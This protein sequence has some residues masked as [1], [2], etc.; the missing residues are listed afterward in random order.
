[1]NYDFLPPKRTSN[2]HRIS[3]K[4]LRLWLLP[5]L[6]AL[7]VGALLLRPA[8]TPTGA[9]LPPEVAAP[10]AVPP[11]PDIRREVID[12]R[13]ASGDTI[14]A[15]LGAYF[16]PQQ[17]H[18]LGQQSRDIFPLSR[19]SAGQPY[20][21][22]LE[23]DRF[24]EFLYDIDRDDQLL[25]RHS[26][27]G[28]TVERIP[29]EYTTTVES[30]QGVIES[31]LFAAV[32]EIGE[33]DTLAMNL[34]DIFAWDIDFI[35]DIRSGD[36]FQALVEKRFRDGEPAG[37]GRLLAARFV[38]R[39]DSFEAIL[40]QDGDQLP[41]Y[42][43]ADGGS[44]RKAF[45]KAPLAFNR[46]SSGFTM[47]RFH[48]IT[49]TWKAHPAIDYAAPR[50][51]PIKTVGDGVIIKKGYT[52]G[53]GNY[54]KIRHNGGYETMYLHMNGFAKSIRQG[55]RVSQGQVIGYVGSTGLATGPHL[56]FR[57]TKNGAPVNPQRIKLPAANPV[58]HDNLDDFQLLASSLLQ[59][60]D[61][62]PVQVAEQQSDSSS[63]HN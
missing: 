38:N 62:A 43:N 50:G 21:L 49:K 10:P 29:I 17:I 4:R 26:A 20:Q 15:L 55:S 30:V 28:F 27:E 42:Y 11:P 18:Q 5:A 8:V 58:S 2:A 46:I 32:A 39:G 23:D 44:L 51:T 59:Q 25:I 22:H 19:L 53:N 7:I 63:R 48:P 56:C 34:A 12:G 13:V 45:L 33:S 37:Y 57:M 3:R 35:L 1:M 40:F 9:T 54:V 16:T 47:R 31:S 41:G 36:S 24:V 61:D 6:A 52:R 14:S 60:M